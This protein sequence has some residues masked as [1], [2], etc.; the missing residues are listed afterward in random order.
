MQLDA[1]PLTTSRK[2]NDKALPEPE[3]TAVER[4]YTAPENELERTFCDLFGEI[5]GLP[6]VGANDNFFEIGGTS[7]S[8]SRV[9]MFA[10]AK[11]HSVTYADVFRLP[12]PREL[13][14]LAGGQEKAS[15][16]DISAS[17]QDEF[18]YAELEPVLSGN[19]VENVD[20]VI[21]EEVGDILLTGATGFLGMHVLYE[22]LTK[23][24]GKAYCLVRKGRSSDVEQRLKTMLAYYFDRP[25]EELFGKR[26]FCIEGDITDKTIVENLKDVSFDTLIN[27]AA[28]VKHFASD[29]SL[30]RI[31]VHGV[32]NLIELC[33]AT[34][35]RLIQVSTVSVAG[36]GKD[37]KPPPDKLIRECDLYFG[38]IINNA[39]IQSK[40]LAERIVLQVITEGLDARI[41][42]VGNLMSR[43]RRRVSD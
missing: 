23:Y 26:I 10:L 25:F 12:T 41:M 30:E 18:N 22:F 42:R 5:L 35:R 27:C 7:L 11:G 36:E 32:Q 33:Q 24:S 39:Y 37:G 14:Q 6:R 15:A 9:A 21:F 3:F 28:L 16:I 29:D 43:D 4:E 20:R 8:A 38:Q 2:I 17:K 19:C 40:F 31:N 13:A 34:G 1:M